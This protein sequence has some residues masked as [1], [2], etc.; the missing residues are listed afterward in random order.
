MKEKVFVRTGNLWLWLIM[1]IAIHH[2]LVNNY[3]Q[4]EA[5]FS[6]WERHKNVLFAPLRSVTRRAFTDDENSWTFSRNASDW[7]IV[8]W[9][10]FSHLW[11]GV[12]NGWRT[13]VLGSFW[14][15]QC[16]WWTRLVTHMGHSN[17]VWRLLLL[18]YDKALALFQN[19]DT[20][21]RC[22]YMYLLIQGVINIWQTCCSLISISGSRDWLWDYDW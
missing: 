6:F 7:H 3:E 19:C 14:P 12:L 22:F 21:D 2:W 5:T 9:L 17:D 16:T 20:A 10:L 18:H 1:V 13:V 4:Q 11:F 8:L 15:T